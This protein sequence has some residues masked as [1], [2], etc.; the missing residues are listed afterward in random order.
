MGEERWPRGA[1]PGHEP[2]AC[3]RVGGWGT[4][5]LGGHASPEVLVAGPAHGPDASMRMG[6]GVCMA[7]LGWSQLHECGV[8]HGAREHGACEQTADRQACWA[9]TCFKEAGAA[10]SV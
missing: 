8:N 7:G 4:V 10:P 6:Q 9:G 2:C 1:S 3:S 5:K